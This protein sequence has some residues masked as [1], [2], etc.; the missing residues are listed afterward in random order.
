MDASSI[1]SPSREPRELLDAADTLAVYALDSRTAN[2]LLSAIEA[3]YT[4]AMNL[5]ARELLLRGLIR[6]L[7]SSVDDAIARSDYIAALEKADD[8]ANVRLR[9]VLRLVQLAL[10]HKLHQEALEWLDSAMQIADATEPHV[11]ADRVYW[12]A[13]YTQDVGHEDP[14]EQYELAAAL[15]AEAGSMRR[16][17][18]CHVRAG[19][20]SVERGIVYRGSPLTELSD[21]ALAAGLPRLDVLRRL[22]DFSALL[23]VTG[24]STL[25]RTWIATLLR[26]DLKSTP[27]QAELGIRTLLLREGRWEDAVALHEFRSRAP[28]AS[29]EAKWLSKLLELSLIA[30]HDPRAV[31]AVLE[32]AMQ[33]RDAD[34][35]PQ[36]RMTGAT[37]LM[38]V[39]A[40]GAAERV[41][42]ELDEDSTLEPSLRA[43]IRLNLVGV[44]GRQGNIQESRSI[45][46][47]VSREEVAGDWEFNG[48]W[49]QNSAYLAHAGGLS[50]LAERQSLAA[51]EAFRHAGSPDQRGN[52]LLNAIT[53]IAKHDHVHQLLDELFE[54][55]PRLSGNVRASACMTLAQRLADQGELLRAT[56]LLDEA[57]HV[58]KSFKDS[59]I[60]AG[61][62]ITAGW[63]FLERDPSM[64]AR[65]FAEAAR[66]TPREMDLHALACYGSAFAS[67]GT[68][69]AR[70]LLIRAA[71]MLEA[72]G[73]TWVAA[74][75]WNLAAAETANA[76]RAIELDGRAFR[77]TLRIV[78]QCADP[79]L[80]ALALERMRPVGAAL[81]DRQLSADNATAALETTY[82]LKS[83]DAIR[84]A[85]GSVEIDPALARALRSA[86]EPRA[87]ASSVVSAAFR[88]AP[89]VSVAREAERVAELLARNDPRIRDARI[90]ASAVQRRLGPREAAVEYL[91]LRDAREVVLFVVTG[92][93]IDALRRRWTPEH[94]EAAR[95]VG[96]VIAGRHHGGSRAVWFPMLRALDDVLLA[97]LR[98]P[99]RRVERLWV[100]PGGYLA[101]V[102]FHAL[103][104]RRMRPAIDR[105]DL[106]LL[107]STAQIALLPRRRRRPVRAVVLRGDDTGF[108]PLPSADLEHARVSSTLRAAG[109][110]LADDAAD[111]PSADVIH[112]AGHAH[113]DTERSTTTLPLAGRRLSDD[114]LAHIA[115]PRRPLLVL[116]ACESGRALASVDTMTGMLRAAFAAGVR[117]VVVSGW[118]AEDASTSALMERFYRHLLKSGGPATAL[119]AAAREVHAAGEHPFFWANFRCY[120]LG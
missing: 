104:D 26:D 77:A 84:P 52:A 34:V 92:D 108:V 53:F 58:G 91:V 29:E 2:T 103:L 90:R 40:V 70:G 19:R 69:R 95:V 3:H 62:L 35:S 82:R 93:H 33:W 66:D 97:P 16:W 7:A 55:L 119:R 22:L 98:R 101:N 88:G 39:S 25:A 83:A 86:M 31:P 50:E 60:V 51:L 6:F 65:V 13:R 38:E 49:H 9:V 64:A 89:T 94:D 61:T 100:A 87:V 21:V 48:I 112:Y 80:R 15:A 79:H 14:T 78:A 32:H 76:A 68:P 36:V 111:I 59:R 120:G 37:V 109:V 106:R 44:L 107:V 10:H 28:D 23:E 113:F 99:L 81:V 67:L 73:R 102:P 57:F 30:S 43:S 11:L 45:F 117:D 96:S 18:D 72:S 71:R 110:S 20:S 8:D 42:R 115:L 114:D 54:L 85:L 1:W 46:E 4:D 47:R 118:S 74:V 27:A 116:S 41:L 63:L 12:L 56:E 105:I 75:A 5:G 24:D 17:F